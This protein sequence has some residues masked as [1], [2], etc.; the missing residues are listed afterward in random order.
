METAQPHW[1]TWSNVNC[2]HHNKNI[3]FYPAEPCYFY[4]F[5]LSASHHAPLW[6]TRLHI[7]Q[8]SLLHVKHQFPKPLMGLFWDWFT[9][10]ATVPGTGIVG[11]LFLLNFVGFSLLC[12]SSL[13]TFWMAVLP[14]VLSA[15]TRES[16]LL[17]LL[18][19]SF[20]KILRVLFS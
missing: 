14:S 10:S 17:P 16:T 12:F 13:S 20:I 19:Y 4:C 5:C 7:L 6:G 15:N 9:L 11:P 18:G 2:L 1:A 3:S 8:S